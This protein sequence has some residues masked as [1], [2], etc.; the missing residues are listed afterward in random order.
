MII[1]DTAL[2]ARVRQ[3][4]PI[5]VALVG[6][7]FSGRIVAYQIITGF[8]GLRLVAI[9]NRTV[10]RANE[11]YARAGVLERLGVDSTPCRRRVGEAPPMW[12]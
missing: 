9:A 2:A 6:A 1:V 5:R 3:G 8:P 10:D 4:N 12:G 7:G 11:A